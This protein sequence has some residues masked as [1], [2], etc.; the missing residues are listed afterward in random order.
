MDTKGEIFKWRKWIPHPGGDGGPG[1]GD[2]GRGMRVVVERVLVS[3]RAVDD[4]S[5]N[6]VHL[7]RSLVPRGP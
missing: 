2:D 7:L 3:V 6:L 1:L 4:A 5:T